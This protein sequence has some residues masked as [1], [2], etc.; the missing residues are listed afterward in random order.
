MDLS[1]RDAFRPY[2]RDLLCGKG[3]TCFVKPKKKKC[4]W[5]KPPGGRAVS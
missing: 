2:S 3:Q 5:S 1:C 4:N